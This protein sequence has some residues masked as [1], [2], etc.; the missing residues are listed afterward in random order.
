MFA[1]FFLWHENLRGEKSPALTVSQVRWL[2]EVVLPE[3]LHV[4]RR[5]ALGVGLAAQSRGPFRD[6]KRRGKQAETVLAH[7]ES[8][9][10]SGAVKRV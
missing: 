8:L 2:L 1:H 9:V 6:R 4:G 7:V 10:I 3:D 5:L